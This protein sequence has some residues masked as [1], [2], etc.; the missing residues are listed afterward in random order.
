M[1]IKNIQHVGGGL[2]VETTDIP[3]VREE[4]ISQLIAQ[5]SKVREPDNPPTQQEAI[6][7]ILRMKKRWGWI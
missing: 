6:E 7:I 3:D 2:V 5:L 1:V 4:E